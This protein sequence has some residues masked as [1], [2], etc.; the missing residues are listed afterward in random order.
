MRK[1][2][3]SI[4]PILEL[5][6]QPMT[7]VDEL[8][9]A[10]FAADKELIKRNAYYVLQAIP[11]TNLA[12]GM[13]KFSAVHHAIGSDKSLMASI[14]DTCVRGSMPDKD[15]SEVVGY[16]ITQGW[17]P[18]VQGLIMN[19]CAYGK[20]ECVKLFH[21]L[22]LY[23]KPINWDY[24]LRSMDESHAFQMVKLLIEFVNPDRQDLLSLRL[25]AKQN[26]S[27]SDFLDQHLNLKAVLIDNNSNLNY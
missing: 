18:K 19:A 25:A 10:L 15:A 14:A 24:C 1:P 11:E 23:K 7:T 22:G 17:A 9:S 8:L 21:T 3:K 20:P 16:L 6:S 13:I 5:A 27:I 2:P 4:Q 26:S 12:A